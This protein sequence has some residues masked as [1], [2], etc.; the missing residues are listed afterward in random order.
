MEN[1]DKKSYSFRNVR[2]IIHG[3]LIVYDK[4]TDLLPSREYMISKKNYT[5]I[6]CHKIKKLV[7]LKC[8]KKWWTDYEVFIRPGILVSF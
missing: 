1:L 6:I 3:L 4:Y 2:E 8:I 5:E 7:M